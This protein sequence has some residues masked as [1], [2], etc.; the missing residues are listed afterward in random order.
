MD[1]GNLGFGS[2]YKYHQFLKMEKVHVG[3]CCRSLFTSM[4]GN[5]KATGA[6]NDPQCSSHKLFSSKSIAKWR[7]RLATVDKWPSIK[8][9]AKSVSLEC[10]LGIMDVCIGTTFKFNEI[11]FTLH[12]NTA[13]RWNFRGTIV[14]TSWVKGLSIYQA[15]EMIVMVVET[16]SPKNFHWIYPVEL[17]RLISYEMERIC[18]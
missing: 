15:T 9:S 1:R 2:T 17:N 11:T 4:L 13:K 16:P 7:R 8:D 12:W 6:K 5:T 18:G 10:D 14:F 3:P